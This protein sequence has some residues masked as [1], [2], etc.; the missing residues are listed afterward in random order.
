MRCE[1][2]MH[3]VSPGAS[4]R[5]KW[6]IAAFSAAITVAE[7]LPCEQTYIFLVRL[8]EKRR[9][10][11]C[12]FAVAPRSG[13][14]GLKFRVVRDYDIAYK[15]APRSGVR[16]LKLR[17]PALSDALL[18]RTPLRGAWIEIFVVDVGTVCRLCRRTPLRGAWIEMAILTLLSA[19]WFSS[20]TPL[21]GA[22]IEITAN[23]RRS[24]AA[25][26]A[27]RSGVRGLKW[28]CPMAVTKTMSVAPRSGVRGLKFSDALL[29]SKISRVAPRSG[30]RGLKFAC[31]VDFLQ[32]SKSHPAQGCVD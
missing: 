4:H 28:V 1:P 29:L 9:A 31:F 6:A 18:R 32:I 24:A 16:G 11:L 21:R 27:P 5:R 15:V 12:M 2:G 19:G 14:R 3:M 20:R 26:V 7:R 8:P 10:E 23:C 13:V 30:V 22:W 25:L 17:S